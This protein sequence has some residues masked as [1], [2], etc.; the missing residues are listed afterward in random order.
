MRVILN[1]RNVKGEKL[2]EGA[3]AYMFKKCELKLN[4]NAEDTSYANNIGDLRDA[5]DDSRTGNIVIPRS[6]TDGN[7]NTDAVTVDIDAKSTSDAENK[8]KQNNNNQNIKKLGDNVNYKI[9]LNNS[10]ESRK[11]MDEVRLTKGELSKMLR[12]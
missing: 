9:N 12:K 2:S 1:K 5:K 8:I 10:V 3:K 6:N 7:P 11:V 4:E